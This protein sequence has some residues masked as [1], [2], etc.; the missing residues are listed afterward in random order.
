MDV[1]EPKMDF[2]S[3][4]IAKQTCSFVLL[5]WCCQDAPGRLGRRGAAGVAGLLCVWDAAVF[6]LLLFLC[7]MIR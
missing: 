6:S 3:V 2:R 5:S 7:L 1:L 4:V